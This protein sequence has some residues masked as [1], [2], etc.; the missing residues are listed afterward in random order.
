[1]LDQSAI[2]R[3]AEL[4]PEEL[5]ALPIGAIVIDLDGT[6]RS[7]NHYESAMSRLAKE[8]VIGRNFFRDV[9]PCTAVQA[10]EGRMQAFL[11][12][13]KRTSETFSYRFAF[14]HGAVDVAITFLLL[15]G[16]KQVLIAVERADAT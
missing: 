3:F 12:A 11:S 10:F 13:K 4:A 9:A 14:A 6:I 5:D 2:L 7:Y 16:D 1:M 8:Q 15:A